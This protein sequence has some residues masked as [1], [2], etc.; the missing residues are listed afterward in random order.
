M[1]RLHEVMKIFAAGDQKKLYSM[2][3]PEYITFGVGTTMELLHVHEKA[4]VT[5]RAQ[6]Y[7]F[8]KK[9]VP[10][11]FKVFLLICQ[12]VCVPSFVWET[13]KFVM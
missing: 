13:S 2:L 12:I 7:H 1:D 3:K 5:K 11:I 10:G 4:S 6:T 8:D 9:N